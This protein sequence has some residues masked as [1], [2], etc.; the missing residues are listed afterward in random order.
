MKH[1]FTFPL[2]LAALSLAVFSLYAQQPADAQN[3]GK[4]IYEQ[5]CAAC[6]GANGDGYGPASVWLY[7]KPRDFSAGLFKIKS[8]P[9]TAL[10]TDA[11][12]LQSITR[13]LPGSSMPSFSYLSEAERRDV[14]QYVRHLTAYTSKS[15]KRTNR[16]EEAAAAGTL[17]KPVEVPAEPAPTVHD[18]ELGRAMF[19]KMQC[20]LC[21]GQT[22][23]G[24][25]PQVPTLKDASGLPVRPRDFNTGLFRGGHTGHDLYLRIHNGMPGTPMVPYGPEQMKPEERWALVHYVQSLR[26]SDVSVNDLLAPEHNAIHVQRVAKLPTDPMGAFWDARDPVRVPL[27]PLWPEPNQVY[28]VA[29]SAVTDGKK[30]AVLLQWRD[31]LP[32]NTAIRVQDFQDGA[33]L[34]FSLSGK[35]GFLGMGDKEN[36]VNLWNWKAGWQAEAEGGGAPDMDSV[37]QSMH[38][39]AWKFT[40]YNTAVSAGN[41]ISQPHNTPIEDANAA[42]FGSFKSQ[43]IKQQ[44]VAGKGI[45]HDGFWSVIFVRDLKSKDADDVKFVAGKPVPVA[46]AIWN[47]EQHDRNGRKMVS[48]WYQLILEDAKGR[49]AQR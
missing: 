29:V 22:G 14:A 6:H 2:S 20:Y 8:T 28:A 9:G 30:L 31:E 43:P 25:G 3:S 26:R 39:D 33:A 46:F 24:D 15:G 36:P 11:D 44:N 48:N 21:H 19:Q 37:Y 17:A 18:L 13:G 41:V 7:P 23:A 12:L 34:Q 27:N 38:V 4:A 5:H 10:P 45:W 16:F 1:E 42:G 47:G 40:N 32:Q 35:Y 49:A